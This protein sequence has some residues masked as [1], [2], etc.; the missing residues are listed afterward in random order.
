V[1]LDTTFSL[2][3]KACG[4]DSIGWHGYPCGPDTGCC[5]GSSDLR[6]DSG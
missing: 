6:D 1:N 2:L 4:W 3:G 5:S